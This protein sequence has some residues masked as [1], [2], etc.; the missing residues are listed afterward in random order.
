M[1]QVEKRRF[2]LN[3][4]PSV[5]LYLFIYQVQNLCCWSFW[6]SIN[7]LGIRERFKNWCWPTSSE[8]VLEKGAHPP[9]PVLQSRWFWWTDP[10]AAAGHRS[11]TGVT[12][13]QVDHFCQKTHWCI[14][15]CIFSAYTLFLNLFWRSHELCL[16]VMEFCP[17]LALASGQESVQVT[18]MLHGHQFF[19]VPIFLFW[20]ASGE[21]KPVIS[22]QATLWSKSRV[23]E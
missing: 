17:V 18:Q 22:A 3:L 4:R 6:P 16:C 9:P 1:L 21:V 15:S 10:A 20:C 12:D 14:S 7:R 2:S 8:A 13:S 5:P 19:F 11:K 23:A